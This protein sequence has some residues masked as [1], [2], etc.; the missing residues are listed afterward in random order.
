[1]QE[2]EIADVVRAGYRLHRLEVYNWGTF[3]EKIWGM[4]PGGHTVLLT[5]ANGSGKSTL[6]DG[7]STLLV[8]PGKRTYNQASGE[9]K[10]ERTEYSYVRGAY[11]RIQDADTQLGRLQYLRKN[12]SNSV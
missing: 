5:G 3:D 7:L 4:T 1:M 11:G 2:P 6:V 12:N 8:P 9:R 10:R